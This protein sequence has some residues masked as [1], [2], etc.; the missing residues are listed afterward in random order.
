M[1]KKE[2]LHQNHRARLKERVLKHGLMG[3]EEHVVLEYMLFHAIPRV[4]TNPIAH[5]LIN[6]FGSFA[7]V[8]D[9]PMEELMKTEGIGQ[10]AAA[11]IK[12]VPQLAQC[13]LIS[14]NK[15]ELYLPNSDAVGRF[16][17]PYFLGQREEQVY[18]LTLDTKM[19]LIKCRHIHSGSFNSVEINVRKVAEAA[20][21]DNAPCVV[22]VHNHPGGMALPSHDDNVTTERLK[23]ALKALDVNLCDHVIIAGQDFVSYADTFPNW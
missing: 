11:F 22:L 13:Y 7:A 4:D 2:N 16:I 23:T 17:L 14:Q 5:R 8:L 1:P 12:L 19:K 10:S 9:A 6:K 21:L 20:I 15:E 3:M 18:L